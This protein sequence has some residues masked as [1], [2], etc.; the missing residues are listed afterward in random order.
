MPDM[1]DRL[2]EMFDQRQTQYQTRM[3]EIT[4][5]RSIR[6]AQRGDERRRAEKEFERLGAGETYRRNVSDDDTNV[7]YPRWVSW[8]PVYGGFLGAAASIWAMIVYAHPPGAFAYAVIIGL[9][10]IAG[11]TA[12]V[13]TAWVTMFLY[14]VAQ[15]S[16]AAIV[17][18]IV[19][20]LT[21]LV[22]HQAS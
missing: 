13:L 6:A 9:G 2:R 7:D 1:W 18:A 22:W 4:L 16:K 21:L 17:I 12:L 11:W 15:Y 5:E 19:A 10:L 14:F 8:I 3:N 20:G